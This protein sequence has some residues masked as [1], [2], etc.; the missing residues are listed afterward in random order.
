MTHYSVFLGVDDQLLEISHTS[1][2]LSA[3]SYF[4]FPKDALAL[5]GVV[6]QPSPVEDKWGWAMDSAL[7]CGLPEQSDVYDI[8]GIGFTARQSVQGVTQPIAGAEMCRDSDPRPDLI[9]TT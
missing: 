6:S 8:G 7:I 9:F 5:M 4:I 2:S 1:L 3:D